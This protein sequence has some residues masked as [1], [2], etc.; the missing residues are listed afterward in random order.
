MMQTLTSPLLK[1]APCHAAG[2]AVTDVELRA[3]IN[4]AL[5]RGARRITVGAGR[6]PAAT[7][8]AAAISTGWERA[9]GSVESMVTWPETAAS[10]LRQAERFCRNGPDLW[11]MTGPTVG[12]SQMTR[13]LL[14]STGWDPARTLATADIGTISTL[15]LVGLHHLNGL[16]GATRAGTTWTVAGEHLR[17]ASAGQAR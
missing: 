17:Q 4:L 7:A 16:T 10:W 1:Y 15:E 2:S 14:W 13:R 3:I 11:I 12:W 5:V 9:G 6:T 8:A